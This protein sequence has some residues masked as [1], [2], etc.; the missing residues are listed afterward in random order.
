MREAGFSHGQSC[1]LLDSL[2]SG[3]CVYVRQ[4]MGFFTSED[5][6][7]VRKDELHRSDIYQM[8]LPR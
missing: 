5:G 7:V 1:C 4:V 6:Y 8:L 3:L 2:R